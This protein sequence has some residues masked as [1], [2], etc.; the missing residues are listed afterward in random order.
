MIGYFEGIESER[1]IAWRL[2]DSL[3]LRCFLG[4]AFD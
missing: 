3:S 1:G 4:I 2:K